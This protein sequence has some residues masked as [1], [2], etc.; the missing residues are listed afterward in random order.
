MVM[1]LRAVRFFA[2]F[3]GALILTSLAA[4][5]GYESHAAAPATLI[6]PAIVGPS[7]LAGRIASAVDGYKVQAPGGARRSLEDSNLLESADCEA[8]HGAL[9]RYAEFLFTRALVYAPIECLIDPGRRPP[10]CDP[11][12]VSL[13][14]RHKPP[15]GARA[16]MF[17]LRFDVGAV[18]R[19]LVTPAVLPNGATNINGT[20]PSWRA[21]LG[22]T[23]SILTSAPARLDNHAI[24]LVPFGAMYLSPDIRA[25]VVPPVM[26]LADRPV[27]V[28][29]TAIV[30]SNILGPHGSATSIAF[31][32]ILSQSIVGGPLH[33]VLSGPNT[34]GG[35]TVVVAALA[36]GT[37]LPIGPVALSGATYAESRAYVPNAASLAVN[38]IYSSTFAAG[39]NPY[40]NLGSA[41]VIFGLRR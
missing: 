2:G 27:Q 9:G 22:G 25:S 37:A 4:A 12:G 17:N 15:H 1:L 13:E 24:V 35:A 33:A 41:G 34:Y 39:G 29:N 5:A 23:L 26:A 40:V 14:R 19:P 28:V 31:S 20:A 16:A 38:G 32:T 21:P 6:C 11:D 18:R 7:L 3:S 10:L 30:P 36:P 8:A